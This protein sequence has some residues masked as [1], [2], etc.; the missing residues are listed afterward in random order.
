MGKASTMNIPE[1]PLREVLDQ[2]A[3]ARPPTPVTA[4]AR[5]THIATVT[6]EQAA[7]A[8][9]AH[10]TRLC[11]HFQAAPPPADATHA[12][13]DLGPFR[14]KWERHTEFSTY[15]FICDGAST[16]PF[17]E[18]AISA[19]PAD[20]LAGLPGE[21][22]A[23]FHLEV[24]SESAP[25]RDPDSLAGLFDNNAIA[26]GMVLDGNARIWTDFRFHADRFGRTLVRAG[27]L[28]EHSLGRLIQRIAELETY[29]AMAMLAF[30]LARDARPR[31]AGAEEE[32]SQI[33]ATLATV[34]GTDAER[35]TL[36]ELSRLAA[37]AE[38]VAADTTF[39]FSA[40]RAYHAIVQDRIRGLREER[41]SSIQ[42]F[43][44]FISRR[45]APAMETCENLARRQES[46]SRRISR[47][48]NLLR[49]RVDVAL[50]AQNRDLL[51]S[52]DRRAQLQLR[53]QETVEGLSVVAISYYLLSLVSYLAKGAMAA[54]LAV[55]DPFLVVT[56][57][58]I[59]VIG[60]VWLGVRRVRRAITREGGLKE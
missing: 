60:L 33:I 13:L 45:L 58:F 2:E 18:P 56:Y 9:H 1:H 44:S 57:A 51:A 7:L 23:A 20:W 41:I 14:L 16:A 22:I 11:S 30:P 35:D 52:M 54:G 10:L 12:S 25:E 27:A 8:D 50:E 49:T 29:R 48:S 24:E 43:G 28:S 55:P 26:G 5:V 39:R 3:H 40:S 46:L 47:A 37:L 34:E 53:L 59:P 15:T 32:L 6:G 4:P 31:V 17:K 36:A 42:P 38:T 21:V 19:V